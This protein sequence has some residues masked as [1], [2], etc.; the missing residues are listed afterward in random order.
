MSIPKGWREILIGA[1]A[2]LL[3]HA[4]VLVTAHL[5]E[6]ADPVL[7]FSILAVLFLG[8]VQ[9]VYVI[10]LI[11][12]GLWRRKRVAIGAG[13]VAVLTGLSSVIGLLH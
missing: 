6:G 2:V 1:G 7:S 12:Y 8:I 11:V 10:P 5:I 9:L 13:I 3:G 4:L